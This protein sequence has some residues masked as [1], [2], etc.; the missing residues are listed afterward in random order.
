MDKSYD[1]TYTPDSSNCGTIN[2]SY[3]MVNHPKHY[4]RYTK[5]VIRM[6]VDI[7]GYADTIKFCEMN[8]FKYRMR[9]GTKPDNDITRDLKKEEWYLNMKETLTKEFYVTLEHALEDGRPCKSE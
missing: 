8:A 1:Y 2:T 5:E 9:M 3:E 4:N 7:W 6:M